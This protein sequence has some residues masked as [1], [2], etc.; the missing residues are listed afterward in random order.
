MFITVYSTEE[1][2]D[3][4]QCGSLKSRHQINAQLGFTFDPDRLSA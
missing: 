2:E 4:K 3:E 1:K